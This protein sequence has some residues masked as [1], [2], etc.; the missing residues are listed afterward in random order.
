MKNHSLLER[1]TELS[2]N[3]LRI[4]VVTHAPLSPE[5]GAGQMAINFSEAL[6]E[7]GHNVTT[8]SPYP[9]P[10]MTRWWQGIQSWW[11]MRLKLDEFLKTQDP[12][13]VVDCY[14]LLLTKEVRKSSLVVARSVQPEILYL[15]S[16]IHEHQ[17]RGLKKI[18]LKTFNCFF[19]PSV[20]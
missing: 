5:F 9:I 12:Y 10:A 13:D 8:W 7:Q 4:L 2:E 3:P 19:L 18:V 16:Q 1:T 11:F 17:D 15:I 20:F 6:K 14:P